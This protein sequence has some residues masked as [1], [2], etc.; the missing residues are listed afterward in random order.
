MGDDKN[1]KESVRA[2]KPNPLPEEK[3]QNLSELVSK[4]D[5][6][7]IYTDMDKIGEG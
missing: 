5:P 3:Q 6:T 4:E 7:K 1:K 2:P